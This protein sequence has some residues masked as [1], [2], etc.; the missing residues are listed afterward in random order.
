MLQAHRVEHF[1]QW[2]TLAHGDRDRSKH[3]LIRRPVADQVFQQCPG[4]RIARQFLA[5][6]QLAQQ[7][8]A[9]SGRNFHQ[10]RIL[11][12]VSAL[13]QALRTAGRFHVG[14]AEENLIGAPSEEILLGETTKYRMVEILGKSD[15]ADVR[16]RF[17]FAGTA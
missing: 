11:Q 13:H 10:T 4:D 8:D 5:D 14:I 6:H 15:A 16:G 7:H 2:R 12:R 9:A 3:L 1:R 17:D